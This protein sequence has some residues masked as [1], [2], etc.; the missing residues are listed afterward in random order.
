MLMTELLQDIRYAIRTLKRSAG[1]TFVIVASLA[2]GIGANTAIFSVVNALLIK[3]L[4]YPA[5]ER[6]VMLW[7]RSPGINIPQDWPS[8]GQYMDVQQQNRSFEAMSISRGGSGAL[9]GLDE[10]QYVE[11]LLTSSSLFPLLGAKPLYGRLLRPDEDAP[12]QPPVAILSHAFWQRVFGGDPAVVGRKITLTGFGGGGGETQNQFEIVG[13]LGPDFLLNDEI[14]P[15]VAS[16]RNTMLHAHSPFV[17][18]RNRRSRG[19]L[20]FTMR[21]GKKRLGA[22]YDVCDRACSSFTN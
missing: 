18:V 15:T 1:L 13:I 10:P 2:I 22:V 4:P 14:M 21:E 8:P 20:S 12:G 17:K 6:L 5:A 19:T 16:I 3:P 7:L 9:L 11:G